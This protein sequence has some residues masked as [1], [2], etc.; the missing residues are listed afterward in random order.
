L[1]GILICLGVG[2]LVCGLLVACAL[3]RGKAASNITHP[4]VHIAEPPRP[5]RYKAH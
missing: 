5:D 2:G 1:R 4:D 3:L